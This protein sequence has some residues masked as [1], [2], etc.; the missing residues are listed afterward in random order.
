MASSITLPAVYSTFA[1]LLKQIPPVVQQH[2]TKEEKIIDLN[3]TFCSHRT[4]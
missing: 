3:A 2:Q 1:L 4:G